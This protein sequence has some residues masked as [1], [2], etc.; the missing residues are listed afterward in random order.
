MIAP[1]VIAKRFFLA[2]LCLAFVMS[3]AGCG[4]KPSKLAS[5]D[6]S[7]TFPTQYPTSR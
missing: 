1:K 4:K 3:V 2:V 7:T 6:E 5:P